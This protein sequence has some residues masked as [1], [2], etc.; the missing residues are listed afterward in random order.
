MRRTRAQWLLV[1]LPLG[2]ATFGL[3]EVFA[4]PVR[5]VPVAAVLAF[6][7]PL[8]L[9]ARQR[10][11]VVAAITSVGAVV[12]MAGLGVDLSEPVAPIITLGLAAYGVGARLPLRKALL[13]G[14]LLVALIMLSAIIEVGAK[15]ADAIF[16]GVLTFGALSM[17]RVLQTH[18]AALAAAAAA[19]RQVAVSQERARIA[20]ELH[21]LIAHSLSVMVVQASAAEQVLRTDPDRAEQAVLAVQQAGRDALSETARLL[22]L[23]RDGPP[24]SAPQP[25][26][27]ALEQLVDSVPGLDVDLQVESALPALPPGAEVSVCRIVQE[28]LTN[29]LKHSSSTRAA[30]RVVGGDAGVTVRVEDPGPPRRSEPLPGGHGLLGM[31]ERVEMYGGALEA[32]PVHGRG[33]VVAASFPAAS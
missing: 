24:D 28:S 16:G 8:P 1:G 2:I 33:W 5:P 3:I 15:G 30:V 19:E 4:Y 32:G 25:G 22:D 21:D 23:L 12:L 31:R 11:P 27:A 14:V 20:R 26:L 9:I 6:L 29:V 18:H 7:S 13:V 10:W 17:G